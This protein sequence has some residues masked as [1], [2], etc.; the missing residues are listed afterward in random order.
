MSRTLSTNSGSADSLKVSLRCGWSEN[1]R[2]MRC[3][4][5]IDKPEALAIERVLQWVA[6]AGIVSNV[7]VTTSAIFSSPILRGA[8]GAGLIGKAVQPF[9]GEPLAPSRHRDAGDP[10]LLGDRE[11]GRA[12]GR[13]KHDPGP[14]RVGTRYLPATC[15]RLELTPLGRVQLDPN[16]RSPGHSR[17]LDRHRRERKHIMACMARYF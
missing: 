15:S 17:L 8:P 10:K 5:E 11:I 1:A 4:V 2:Q 3:T 7:V 14:H 13:Q 12:I 6:A 9:G 16:R